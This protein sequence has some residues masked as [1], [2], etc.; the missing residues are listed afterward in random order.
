MIAKVLFQLLILSA[1][2]ASI[3]QNR[4]YKLLLSH[5][6][7]TGSKIP[8]ELT[9]EYF[10]IDLD[11][12]TKQVLSDRIL[13]QNDRFTALAVRIPCQ[14]DDICYDGR[15]GI[16][17][18]KGKR[19]DLIEDFENHWS[20]DGLDYKR[21]CMIATDSVLAFYKRNFEFEPGNYDEVIFNEIVVIV[22]KL[23]KKGQIVNKREVM[24]DLRREHSYASI[25]L[26]GLGLVEMQNVS[27]EEL[28]E[29][30]NEILASHG[31][32][33]KE[34][35]WHD[36]FSKRDWYVSKFDNVDHLL[37]PIEHA[38]LELISKLLINMK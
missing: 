30:K 20:E 11:E 33:F 29:I 38:N 23:S 15:L 28:V 36:Y 9:T 35:K 7:Q 8:G 1:S 12:R 27:R 22:M 14:S 24:I 18:R 16:F 21:E 19:I 37:T 10:G 34:L 5:F 31:L 3:A 4:E 32:N 13:L 26:F 6:E 25:E 17:N 2:L